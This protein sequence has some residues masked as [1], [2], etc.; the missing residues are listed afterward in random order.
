[1]ALWVKV[2]A[3]KPIPRMHMVEMVAHTLKCNKNL[4]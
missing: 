4:N 2:L 1:M 3:T